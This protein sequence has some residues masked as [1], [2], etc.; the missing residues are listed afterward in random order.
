MTAF[1]NIA[2]LDPCADAAKWLKTQPDVRTAGL[3]CPR[4]RDQGQAAFGSRRSVPRHGRDRPRPR[5]HRGGLRVCG[6]TTQRAPAGISMNDMLGTGLHLMSA[7][8]LGP[9]RTYPT[10]EDIKGHRLGGVPSRFQHPTHY[11]SVA[12]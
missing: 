4:G 6:D 10:L 1:D 12:D 9:G 7:R 8:T 5:C 2:H 3:L 11:C